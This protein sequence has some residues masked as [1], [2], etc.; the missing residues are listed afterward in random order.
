MYLRGKW[1]S[2]S[3]FIRRNRLWG[4]RKCCSAAQFDIN[5]T[6][7]SDLKIGAYAEVN[8]CFNQSSVKTFSDI[9]GDNNPLHIDDEVAKASQFGGTIVHGILVSSLFST[10]FGRTIPG[11]IYIN[12]SMTFRKP[13]KV[14]GKI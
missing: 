9:S 12:Q 5:E 13:V 1:G 3:V 4:T 2:L 14:G 10:L 7:T 8:H 11:S 6:L